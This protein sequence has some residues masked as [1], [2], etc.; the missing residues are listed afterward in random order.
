MGRTRDSLV[1][2]SPHEVGEEA[3]TD[4]ELLVVRKRGVP[5]VEIIVVVESYYFFINNY[6]WTR[7]TAS[8]VSNCLFLYH[9]TT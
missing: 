1:D 4:V 5:W 2:D 3:L 9:F 8:G 6:C 7:W